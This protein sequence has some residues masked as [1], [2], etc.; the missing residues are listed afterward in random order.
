MA[1]SIWKKNL[2]FWR[3]LFGVCFSRITE[4]LKIKFWYIYTR[5]CY[6]AIKKE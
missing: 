5:E 4:F 2:N 1:L 3:P 6:L